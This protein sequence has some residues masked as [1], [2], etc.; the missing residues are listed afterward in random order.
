MYSAKNLNKQGDNIQPWHT[1]FPIWNLSIVPCPV[2][3]VASWPAYR[4]LKRQVRWSGILISWRI[5][6]NLC[7]FCKPGPR[8]KEQWPWKRLIQMPV[9]V[10][11]SQAEVWVGDGL[12]QGWGTQWSS[13]CIGPFKWG[14]HYLH[15]LHHSLASGQTTGREHSPIHQQKVELKI[16][17][18]WPHSWKQISYMYMPSLWALL[19][20]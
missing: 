12:L 9:N 17:W 1:P 11:E 19:P 3:T 18:V 10:Q 13:V 7:A 20:I 2:L 4:F 6:H 14:C 15:Y 5:F 8:R 16:Y